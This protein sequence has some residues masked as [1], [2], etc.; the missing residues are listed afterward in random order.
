MLINPLKIQRK[1]KYVAQLVP[2]KMN[3]LICVRAL[4]VVFVQMDCGGSKN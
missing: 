4:W 2:F 3:F 1:H